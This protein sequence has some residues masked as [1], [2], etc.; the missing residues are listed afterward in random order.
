MIMTKKW[1]KKNIENKI[2]DAL[3]YSGSMGKEKILSASGLASDTLKLFLKHKYGAKDNSDEFMQNHLG[4]LVHESLAE[5]FKDKNGYTAE[6]R[7]IIDNFYNDWSISGEPDLVIEKTVTGKKVRV[8]VDWKTFKLKKLQKVYDDTSDEHESL[9]IQLGAYAMLTGTSRKKIDK[10]ECYVAVMV[11]DATRFGY[12]SSKDLVFVKIKHK[13]EDEIR[14]LFKEK[15]DE[16][17]KHIKNGTEPKECEFLGWSAPMKGAKKE[18]LVC[19]LFCG[20]NDNCSY[21][22][23]GAARRKKETIKNRFNLI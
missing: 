14:K 2:T 15:V 11:K 8:I 6:K 7:I 13:S 10:T 12:E 23:I 20:V 18:K 16:I 17:E 21:Y 3:A 1:L 4:T 22:S 9:A 19:K 5:I